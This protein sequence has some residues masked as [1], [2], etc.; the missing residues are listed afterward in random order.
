MIFALSAFLIISMI[1]L[2][3]VSAAITNEKRVE[4]EKAY[5]QAYLTAQSIA[6]VLNEQIIA[7]PSG[8]GSSTERF[9]NVT[10]VKTSDEP[11]VY[12]VDS[13]LMA[14]DESFDYGFVEPIGDICIERQKEILRLESSR[15][16][17]GNLPS[18]TKLP[19][20]TEKQIT[21]NADFTN[22]SLPEEVKNQ[23]SSSKIYLYMPEVV[24]DSV[25]DYDLK[26]R[27]EVPFG[28]TDVGSEFYETSITFSGNCS[29][30]VNIGDSSRISI[31][32]TNSEAGK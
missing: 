24:A 30:P 4:R 17:S 27:I 20:T 1:S 12:D 15:D 7:T 6:G 8:D 16:E 11:A 25:E 5:E 19:A 3:I 29:E 28:S 18:G 31:W 21:L 10:Y 9:V 2:V 32:W 13:D 22:C 14:G 23:I 26:L